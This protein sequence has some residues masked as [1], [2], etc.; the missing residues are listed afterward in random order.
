[1]ADAGGHDDGVVLGDTS[2]LP[3]GNQGRH[4]RRR[5]D[6]RV[7]AVVVVA[8]LGALALL[9]DQAFHRFWPFQSLKDEI[10]RIGSPVP[11]ASLSTETTSGE[12]YG[13]LDDCP[14]V[15]AKWRLARP[16][17][18]G[19]L[20]LPITE[21]LRMQGYRQPTYGGTVCWEAPPAPAP[22]AAVSCSMAFVRNDNRFHFTVS[23]PV[24]TQYAQ[25]VTSSADFRDHNPQ[26]VPVRVDPDAPVRVVEVSIG[27]G[28][29]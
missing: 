18:L 8:L 19:S 28:S 2:V 12:W 3:T 9:G 21:R 23:F 25:V 5:F 11:G 16:A 29:G 17:D 13:C 22:N 24:S 20:E 6:R 4:Q 15:A 10:N 14:T 7:V 1:M 26:E 27:K